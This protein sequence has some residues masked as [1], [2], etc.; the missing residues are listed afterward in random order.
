MYYKG[1]KEDCDNYNALVT[2]GQN[3]SGTTTQWAEPYEVD[4]VWYIVKNKKYLSEMEEVEAM[5]IVNQETL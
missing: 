2:E 5:P 3:Y 1:T 4:G